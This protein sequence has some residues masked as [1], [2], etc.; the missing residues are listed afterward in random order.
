MKQFLPVTYILERSRAGKSPLTFRFFLYDVIVAGQ[1]EKTC[2]GCLFPVTYAESSINKI[3][4][5]Q[6]YI[7]VI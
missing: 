1:S 6:I 4:V 5:R 7:L 2:K 3:I